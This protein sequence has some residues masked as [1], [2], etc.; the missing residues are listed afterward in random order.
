MKNE[1]QALEKAM[2]RQYTWNRSEQLKKKHRI[3]KRQAMMAYKDSGLKHS[4]RSKKDWL[5][6]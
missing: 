6:S 5:S 3:G 4:R 1:L 2:R